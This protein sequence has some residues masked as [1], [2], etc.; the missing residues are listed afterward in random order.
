MRKALAEEKLRLGSLESAVT[1]DPSSNH[2]TMSHDMRID[3]L[4][5]NSCALA[6]LDLQWRPDAAIAGLAPAAPVAPP[7]LP[8]HRLADHPS[9][10]AP[11]HPRV[12]RLKV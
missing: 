12:R 8:L 7:I 10:M 4:T 1:T 3:T 11:T 6:F 5:Q 9:A 2:V